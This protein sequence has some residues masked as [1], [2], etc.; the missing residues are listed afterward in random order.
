MHERMHRSRAYCRINQDNISAGNQYP[1]LGVWFVFSAVISVRKF[2]FY[3][4]ISTNIF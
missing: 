2:K 1:I 3:D 4:V